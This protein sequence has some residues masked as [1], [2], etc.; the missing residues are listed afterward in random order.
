MADDEESTEVPTEEGGTA[1]LT[2]D[3]VLQEP[4]EQIGLTEVDT[5]AELVD[6]YEGMSFQ[7]RSL[8]ECA[9]V[10][11]NALDDPDRP[12]VIL[13]IAGSLMAGGLRKAFRD[14]IR[15]GIVDVVVTAGSQP[16]QDLYAARG[17]NDFWR[18]SPDADDLVLRDLWL[19]RLYDT[20]VDE[21][22]FRE[23]D[24]VLGDLFH[25]L[26]PGTY[27]SRE[28]LRHFGEAFDD[29][30]SWLVAA[31]EHDVPV[32]APALN[33]SSIGIGMVQHHVQAREEG[34]EPPR[35]DPIRDHYELAQ[36]KYTAGKTGVIYLGGGV[37]KNHIQQMEVVS[38][39]LGY[40]PGGHQYAV[41]LTTDAP[42]WGGL[43]GCT[44]EEAQSWGKIARDATKATAYVDVTIGF[45]LIAKAAMEATDVDTRPRL[46]FEYEDDELVAIDEVPP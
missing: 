23:T 35:I 37:P 46:R 25:E 41:Q 13:G 45:P 29:D 44:L 26:D 40:E 43:S 15:A 19:D 12:P 18:S 38:E 17:E 3:D 5:V 7:A 32:F 10:W 9:R 39:I 34:R 16:Y 31:A 20:V 2:R 33:D 21:K 30:A 6:A 28:I 27:T 8:G 24:D 4:V 36:I 22:Q 1:E 11:Q 14:V 42:H